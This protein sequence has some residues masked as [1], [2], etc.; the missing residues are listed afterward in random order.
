MIITSLA[1]DRFVQIVVLL[2]ETEKWKCVP[3]SCYIIGSFPCF[4]ECDLGFQFYCFPYN[5]KHIIFFKNPLYLFV[6]IILSIIFYKHCGS[7]GT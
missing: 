6:G 1:T 4:Y 3:F 5:N 7:I 2:T